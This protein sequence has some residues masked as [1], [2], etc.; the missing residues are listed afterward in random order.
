MLVKSPVIVLGSVKYG[1]SSVILKTYSRD[2][3]LISYIAGGVRGKK[4][5]LKSA[6]MLP[7]NQMEAVFYDKSKSNLRRL[8]EVS[9]PKVYQNM[10]Y[11]PVKNCICM[12]LAEVLSHVLHEEEPQEQLFDFLSHSFYVLDEAEKGVANFHLPFLFEL[13]AFLG[14]RPE[15][16]TKGSYFDLVNGVYTPAEPPHSHYIKG[17]SL[18]HWK[19]LEKLSAIGLHSLKLNA[20]SRMKLLQL[21]IDYYRLHLKDFGELKSLDVLHTILR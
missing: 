17:D 8:K 21:L 14:F 15:P 6:I 10:Y 20:D 2:F 3:G 13:S 19:E 5:G 12:F 16:Y 7:L 4:G 18:E 11:D 1:D 9:S